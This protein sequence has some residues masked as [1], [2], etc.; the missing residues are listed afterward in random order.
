MKRWPEA[1]AGLIAIAIGFGL[2][3]GCPL[4]TPDHVP[5]W[6]RGFVE[7]VR[8]AQQVVEWPVSWMT[9]VFRVSQQ[10]SLYQAPTAE[11]WRLW[12]EGELAD[13]SWQIVYR[14]GDTE[15][16]EDAA[17]I[18]HARVWGTWDP[19]DAP[20]AEYPAFAKWELAR[21]L[22][23]HPEFV[24]ARA[25]MERIAIGQGEITPSGTFEW[26]YLQVRP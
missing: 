25:R 21:V 10:W 11:R 13:R 12:I 4:A 20:A 15:H 1:R 22:A 6:E 23:A 7:P 18:E 2:V 19:T 16:A 26:T 9:R 14:A 17:L 24:A 3:D 5:E 8:S